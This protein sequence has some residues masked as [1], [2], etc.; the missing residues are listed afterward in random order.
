MSESLE[1]RGSIG[2][3]ADSLQRLLPA[4]GMQQSI[5]PLILMGTAEFPTGK[6]AA[7]AENLPGAKWPAAI[8]ASRPRA[9]RL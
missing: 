2:K 4:L 9:G 3:N 5:N 6:S 1:T 8:F 7:F